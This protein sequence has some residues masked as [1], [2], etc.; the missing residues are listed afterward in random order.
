M[1]KTIIC[2]FLFFS[3]ALQFAAG[4]DLKTKDGKIY[5]N[6]RIEAGNQNGIKIL[7]SK[8]LSLIP[9]YNLPEK[10]AEQY[11][12]DLKVRGTV[13][14]NYKVVK[15]SSKGLK[16]EH[17]YGT[18]ELL[19]N[20]LPDFLLK[21]YENQI[22]EKKAEKTLDQT[23][24]DDG[25]KQRE[26]FELKPSDEVIKVNAAGSGIT[27]EEALV[28]ACQDAVRVAKGFFLLSQSTLKGDNLEEKIYANTAG[29]VTHYKI[30]GRTVDKN[31]IIRL[32]IEAKVISNKVYQSLKK[33]E[34]QEISLT[35]INNLL[36]QKRTL[37]EAEKTINQIFELYIQN[38]CEINKVGFFAPDKRDN[39]EESINTIV[40]Y[41][42]KFN[43]NAFKT[44]EQNLTS[45]LSKICTSSQIIE[46]D[47]E[48]DGYE[49]RKI[50]DTFLKK[51]QSN[52]SDRLVYFLVKENF[53]YSV[54]CYLL[55]AH[56]FNIIRSCCFNR[57]NKNICDINLD[58]ECSPGEILFQKTFQ[59]DIRSWAVTT[60][61]NQ[62]IMFFDHLVYANAAYTEN[63]QNDTS[64]R[65]QTE[66]ISR[67]NVYR[68][69]NVRPYHVLYKSNTRTHYVYPARSRN[70]GA[71]IVH[72]RPQK[73][74][75]LP[76]DI[77]PSDRP[78]EKISIRLPL[79]EVRK[80][81]YC[82]F[83]ISRKFAL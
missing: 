69:Q 59:A 75:I 22:A 35:D 67:R 20:E 57:G 11:S 43:R 46:C 73:K 7:H 55:S 3:F 5:Y 30:T 25:W 40:S 64:F 49:L 71:P 15:V 79:D 66:I 38:G 42:V 16:I 68:T 45:L 63:H 24:V 62:S 26:E 81:K 9:L 83:T 80:L 4:E 19:Y 37:V 54:K 32:S 6:Y 28:N 17:K 33:K 48:P 13:Y 77:L 39:S 36:V 61:E 53:S 2:F 50:E 27:D 47:D 14:Y 8:G 23:A 76:I 58:L 29:V 72:P 78:P 52:T 65:P 74:S 44:F 70:F 82:K 60:N 1:I 41:V 18:K 21:R 10:I 56:I 31:G 51:H 12:A 34:H